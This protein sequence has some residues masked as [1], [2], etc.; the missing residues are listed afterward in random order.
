MLSN[1][2]VSW[3]S[4]V[5]IHTCQSCLMCDGKIFEAETM[6]ISPPIH[7]RCR[8][9]IKWIGAIFAGKA[10]IHGEMG[11]DWWLKYRGKLPEYY[12]TKEE[13]I[14]LGW[15]PLQGNF[16]EKCYAKMLYGGLFKNRAGKLPVK[17]GRVWY[18]A[19]INYQKGFRTSDRLLFSN[20]GLIFVTYDHYGTFYEVI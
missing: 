11:A 1:K 4:E 2:F 3:I 7:E 5:D 13:A 12:I 16:H 19:D 18:E 6:Y 17:D 8:C 14:R 10:T 9:R 20:D 15:V